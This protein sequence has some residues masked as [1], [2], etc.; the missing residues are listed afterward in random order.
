MLYIDEKNE[1]SLF[2]YFAQDEEDVDKSLP[3][4]L[5]GGGFF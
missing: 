1:R 4:C 2:H 3:L 5:N